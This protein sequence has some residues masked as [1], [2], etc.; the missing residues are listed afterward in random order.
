MI[1]SVKHVDQRIENTSAEANMS[2][3]H[4]RQTIKPNKTLFI[5]FNM[6]NT[7]CEYRDDTGFRL[8]IPLLI[9]STKFNHS[10][11]NTK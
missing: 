1:V 3:K 2:R 10:I 11:I 4:P 9:F 6:N 7:A 5:K 8:N